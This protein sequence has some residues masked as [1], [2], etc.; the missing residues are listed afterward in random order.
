MKLSA[1]SELVLWCYLFWRSVGRF[2]SNRPIRAGVSVKG[3]DCISLF[4]A[5]I[6]QCIRSCSRLLLIQAFYIGGFFSCILEIE[7]QSTRVHMYEIKKKV[8]EWWV[9]WLVLDSDGFGEVGAGFLTTRLVIIFLFLV[10]TR[11]AT[12][13]EACLR[14]EAD[15]SKSGW[16]VIIT[17]FIVGDPLQ[18]RTSGAVGR[19]WN[20]SPLL[21]TGSGS[22]C[23]YSRVSRISQ[24]KG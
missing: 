22:S 11:G 20:G 5:C 16:M 17:F 23:C 12:L 6:H 10:K 1:G 13:A 15:S 9:T 21:V 19:K 14:L 24:V 4:F 7:L 18:K 3:L 2:G 8:L